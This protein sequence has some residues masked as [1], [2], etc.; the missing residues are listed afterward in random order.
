MPIRNKFVTQTVIVQH[1]EQ[2]P[3]GNNIRLLPSQTAG[4]LNIYQ[5]AQSQKSDDS[6]LKCM[7]E[8]SAIAEEFKLNSCTNSI[9]KHTYSHTYI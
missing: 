1:L 7:N 8:T 3:V 5:D 2:H 6:L 9:I 4:M